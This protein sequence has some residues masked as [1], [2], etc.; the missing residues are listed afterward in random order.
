MKKDRRMKMKLVIAAVFAASVLPGSGV[1]QADPA[2]PSPD[3]NAPKCWTT[4]PD[5]DLQ[6]VACGWTYSHSGG[7]QQVS[8]SP[9][10]E[11]P[12]GDANLGQ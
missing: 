5:G 2:K 12:P 4:G 3:P 11:A 9:T 6:W 10:P 1:A 8:P 7:W